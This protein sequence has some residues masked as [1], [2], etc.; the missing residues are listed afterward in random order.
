MAFVNEELLPIYPNGW[1]YDGVQYPNRIFSEWGDEQLS[2][3][4]VY[5]VVYDED[6]VP[7]GKML[8]GWTYKIEGHVANASP[9]YIDE[10]VVIPENVSRAQG[11]AALLA[12]GM[13]DAV[14]GYINTLEGGDKTL[15]LL[16]FNE[17]NEWRRDSPFLNQAATVLGVTQ[18]QMDELFLEASKIAL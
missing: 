15:A 1:V 9:L 14:E 7:E 8:D 16:A 6:P 18:E 4:G 10:V 2:S 3:V 11:K 5:R 12:A 13:L 17:T